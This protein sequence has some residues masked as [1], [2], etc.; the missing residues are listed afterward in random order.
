[1]VESRFLERDTQRRFVTR[2]EQRVRS[3]QCT[4]LFQATPLFYTISDYDEGVE[5]MLYPQAC[6]LC[7]LRSGN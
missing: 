3:Q 1:M 4:G 5:D 7:L 2:K 6:L